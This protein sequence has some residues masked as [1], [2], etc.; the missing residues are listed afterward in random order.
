ML[1]LKDFIELFKENSI[2]TSTE[3]DENSPVGFISYN[4]QDLKADTLFFC[5]GAHFK[6]QFLLDALENGATAYVSEKKY[7]T[8]APCI[9]VSDIRKSMYLSANF[10]Y[11]NAWDKLNLVGITGT[12]GKSTTAYFINI[13]KTNILLPL[14]RKRVLLYHQLTLM[15]A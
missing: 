4:S 5:K 13:L 2:L 3:C 8:D 9:L 15:M 6:E 14:A 1:T 11:N 7:N 10:F 12:K